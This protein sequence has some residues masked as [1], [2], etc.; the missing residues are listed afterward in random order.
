MD[1]EVYSRPLAYLLMLVA[2][3]GLLGLLLFVYLSV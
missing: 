2:I 3:V 1:L